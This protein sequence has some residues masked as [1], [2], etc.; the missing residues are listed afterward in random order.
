MT[1][2]ASVSLPLACDEPSVRIVQPGYV[3]AVVATARAVLAASSGRAFLL[4]T[5]HRA[6]R[7]A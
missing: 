5:S 6:L 1:S 7:A 4:F 3:E 2:T